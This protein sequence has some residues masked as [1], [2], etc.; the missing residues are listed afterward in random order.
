MQ[1]LTTT[2]TRA[3]YRDCRESEGNREKL[4]KLKTVMEYR[5]WQE[6]GEREREEGKNRENLGEFLAA[7]VLFAIRGCV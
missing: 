1:P 7:M 4:G 5:R 3:L 6:G 2:D